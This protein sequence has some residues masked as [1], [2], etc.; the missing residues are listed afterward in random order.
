MIR[1]QDRLGGT[2]ARMLLQVHDELLIEAPE[3]DVDAIGG[4]V[5]DEMEGAIEL[6]V[7]LKVDLGVGKSWYDCK[8]AKPESRA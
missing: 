5:R 6:D 1:L 4:L 8:F 7:P 2:D 3:A